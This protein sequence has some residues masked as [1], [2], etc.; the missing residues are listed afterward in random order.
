MYHTIYEPRLNIPVLQTE[1]DKTYATEGYHYAQPSVT[2]HPTYKRLKDAKI[3]FEGD[4]VHREKPPYQS[5]IV[6]THR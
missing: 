1:P 3:T 5:A 2:E 6:D 4:E